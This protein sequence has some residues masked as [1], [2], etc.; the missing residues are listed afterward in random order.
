[1]DGRRRMIF[2]TSSA[3]IYAVKWLCRG[4]RD[5]KVS[6]VPGFGYDICPTP[7][8]SSRCVTRD[9]SCCSHVGG[10]TGCCTEVAEGWW[11]TVAVALFS[12]D[13]GLSELI[14]PAAVQRGS[15][16]L[17]WPKV[18]PQ[19]FQVR[20]MMPQT[21]HSC[22]TTDT[23]FF[24]KGG[25]VADGTGAGPVVVVVGGGASR[26]SQDAETETSGVCLILHLC[27]LWN[28]F[29]IRQRE[30]VS[31]EVIGNLSDLSSGF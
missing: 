3:Q 17:R 13:A 6:T 19:T 23:T 12:L 15:I 4:E 27:M 8:P 9:I 28:Y 10:I 18:L 1:M 7:Y 25:R 29:S 31:S 20:V 30:A 5:Y 16:L 24:G 14:R 2:Q 22:H 26:I 21:C 11:R